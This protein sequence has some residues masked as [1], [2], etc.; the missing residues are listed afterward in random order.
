[1]TAEEFAQHVVYALADYA[2]LRSAR[3]EQTESLPVIRIETG[4]RDS[5]FI[6]ITKDLR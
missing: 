5:F 6:V 1:M 3:I 2:E 4:D